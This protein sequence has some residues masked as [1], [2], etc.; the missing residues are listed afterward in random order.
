MAT[1]TQMVHL[2]NDVGHLTASRDGP[3]SDRKHNSM[4]LTVDFRTS[5]RAKNRPP[6]PS[7]TE[8][9]ALSASGQPNHTRLLDGWTPSRRTPFPT[10]PLEQAVI[11][12]Q[13]KTLWILTSYYRGNARTNAYKLIT[14]LHAEPEQRKENK[15]ATATSYGAIVDLSLFKGGGSFVS[16]KKK[17]E[18]C[19]EDMYCKTTQE[20]TQTQEPLGFLFLLFLCSYWGE[21]SNLPFNVPL[22][23]SFAENIISGKRTNTHTHTHTNTENKCLLHHK[24]W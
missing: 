2:E 4:I 9:E 10:Q 24:Q 23:L 14:H 22:L 20:I 16:R 17:P 6:R 11:N 3:A 21:F 15:S 1:I 7:A 5:D 12:K 13:I 8:P 19:T 18:W